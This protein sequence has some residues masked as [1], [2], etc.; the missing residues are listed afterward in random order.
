MLPGYTAPKILWL[1]QN[2]PANFRAT[3]SHPAA[4]RLPQFLADGRASAWNTATPRARRC[5]TCATREWSEPILNFIDPDLA[6]LLPPL[7]SSRKPGGLLRETLRAEWGLGANVLVER[8]RRRQHDGGHRH[9]QHRA[10]RRGD[11]Q[12]RHERHDLRLQRRAGRGRGGRNRRVLRQ[13]GRLAAAGVHDERDGGHRAGPATCSAGTTPR[14]KPPSPRAAPGAGGLLFLPYLN[15]ERTP[16]LPRGSGVHARVDHAQHDAGALRPRG[17]GGRRRSVS[18]TGWTVSASLGVKPT[19]IRLT[20]GGSQSAAWRQI[21]ADVFGVPVFAL[22]TTEGAALGAAIQAALDRARRAGQKGASCASWSTASCIR[23][24][25]P[26]RTRRRPAPALPGSAFKQTDM[27]RRLH[28]GGFLNEV[29]PRRHGRQ[30]VDL[31][32]AAAGAAGPAGA[33]GAS[34]AERARQA[35][36]GRGAARRQADGAGGRARAR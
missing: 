4:A 26:R 17:D 34:R 32:R 20:G 19:E 3:R 6:E 33:R 9:G 18:A 22:E 27:T 14:W 21:C 11:G 10:G 29:R 25:H 13:H 35:G 24:R 5:S 30:R 8:G 31:H 2:E 12:P 36:R 1:K 15:G 23:P 7:E 28:G 16:N